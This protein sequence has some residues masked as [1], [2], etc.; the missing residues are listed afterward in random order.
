M[1][2][3]KAVILS[4]AMFVGRKAAGGEGAEQSQCTDAWSATGVRI[5]HVCVP[6]CVRACNLPTA[7]VIY[8]WMG[9][10]I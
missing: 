10:G 5:R 8:N 7:I 6:A 2:H 9:S 1:E 3:G 4:S